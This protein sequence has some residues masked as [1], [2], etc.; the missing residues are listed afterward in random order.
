MICFG[1]AGSGIGGK[2]WLPPVGGG[3][4]LVGGVIDAERD[5]CSVPSPMGA[6]A[7]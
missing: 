1:E 5:V 4:M 6:P 7:P 2:P 3:V